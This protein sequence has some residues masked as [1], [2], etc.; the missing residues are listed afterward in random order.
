MVTQLYFWLHGGHKAKVEKPTQRLILAQNLKHAKNY[1]S[2][3]SSVHLV[4]KKKKKRKI[5]TE[6]INMICV[7]CLKITRSTHKLIMT[8]FCFVLMLIVDSEQA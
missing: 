1:I 2:L 6:M 7:L 5:E 4:I 8:T 3:T